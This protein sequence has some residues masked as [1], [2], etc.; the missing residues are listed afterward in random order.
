MA[1][2]GVRTGEETLGTTSVGVGDQ[3]TVLSMLVLVSWSHGVLDKGLWEVTADVCQGDTAD[4]DVQGRDTLLSVL[5]GSSHGVF[6]VSLV[7]STEAEVQGNVMSILVLVH[8]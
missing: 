6:D 2:V 8:A 4:K 1:M 7:G 3:S 5:A